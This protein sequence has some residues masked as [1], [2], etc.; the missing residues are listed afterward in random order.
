[1]ETTFSITVKAMSTV[2]LLYPHC[3]QSQNMIKKIIGK[4]SLFSLF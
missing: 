3:N 1:M 4:I 2:N